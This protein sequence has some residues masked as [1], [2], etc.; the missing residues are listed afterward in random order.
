MQTRR[1]TRL[2]VTTSTAA[3]VICTPRIARSLSTTATT[4]ALSAKKSPADSSHDRNDKDASQN[5]KTITTRKSPAKRIKVEEEDA[6]PA[7]T[8]SPAKRRKTTSPKK[9]SATVT[10]RTTVS[11][12]AKKT[13]TAKKASTPAKATTSSSAKKRPPQKASKP[14]P[15]SAS[16]PTVKVVKPPDD[17]QET[18][19]LV[20]ELRQD[21]TAPVD[22]AGAEVLPERCHGDKVF[23]FQ[24]LIC[25]MLSSQT[26][27]AVVGEAVR[28][29][30]QH[31]LTLE[32]I[33][34][35]TTPEQL[36]ALIQKVG[37]HNNK[38]TY[39]KK[40]CD[41]L[42]QNYEGD[43]PKTA[44]EM[45]DNLPG[46][47]PKM[48]FL[49]ET[50]AWGTTS[51]IGVDVHMNRMF[52]QIGWVSS[53]TPEQT[54]LQLESWLPRELWPEVNYI[55]VGFG[56]ESQQ[57]KPKMLRKALDCSRPHDALKLLKKVGV[58]V[59]KESQKAG[60]EDEVKAVMKPQ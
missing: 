58:D 56:Q 27:D 43:I 37:F 4:T 9:E 52:N 2:A 42:L 3:T 15:K 19:A 49:I 53:K 35:H 16:S 39:I 25:L 44:Q 40:V 1:S 7:V 47:G 59:K 10:K 20:K 8:P 54:R 29:L 21:K 13:T 12:S 23:R 45:I 30:Q 33:A 60:W 24:V 34:H 51:G 32:N 31:G 46:I 26:K 50:I 14:K 48:A 22:D 57:F 36:N 17:W 18:Y 11:A 6:S 41:I 28:G 38:T 5:T 55:W